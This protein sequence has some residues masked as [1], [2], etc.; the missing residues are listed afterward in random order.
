MSVPQ[1]IEEPETA[2]A[3][4]KDAVPA[5]GIDIRRLITRHGSD[6]LHLLSSQKLGQPLIS[7]FKQ[8]CEVTPVDDGVDLWHL[9]QFLNQIAKVRHHFRGASRNIDSRNI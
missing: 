7:W 9:P 3:T 6:D 4:I 1:S 5:L 8:N 2:D